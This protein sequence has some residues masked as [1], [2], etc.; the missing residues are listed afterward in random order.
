M[1]AAE[2]EIRS[3]RPGDETKI[4]ELFNTVFREENPYHVDR[5]IDE[6]RYIFAGAGQDHQSMV[7]ERT[8]DGLFIG[9]YTAIPMDVNIRGRSFLVGQAVDTCVHP[10]YRRSLKREGVFLT[11]AWTWFDTWGR[12]DKD[13]IVY[14]FPNTRAF[15]VGT[16]VLHY[17]PV[18]C[19]IPHLV[20]AS[21]AEIP[22]DGSV[23][24]EP[25][26]GFTPEFEGYYHEI[27]D[28][29]G[30]STVRTEKYLTWRYTDHPKVDYRIAVARRRGEFA[31]YV[32]YRIGWLDKATVPLVDI[33][34]D[35][36][37]PETLRALV[38][39]IARDALLEKQETITAWMPYGFR[40]H[41]TL[42]ELG[43]RPEEGPFNLCIRIFNSWMD[44]NDARERW[45]YTMG[46]S[47]IY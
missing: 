15:P 42:G 5:E 12:E 20:L 3:Y 27:K 32:I 2:W 37:D 31:G 9:L 16:R 29:L 19:P 43:F 22:T 23:E 14:G 46:D 44:M 4:L 47:D 10:D 24:V 34:V 45:Y 8:S 35:P 7:A 30:V 17:R 40:Q 38:A 26:D 18:H 39:S 25:V 41:A 21:D 6:W 1:T 28:R 36:D 11:L 13:A 33:V